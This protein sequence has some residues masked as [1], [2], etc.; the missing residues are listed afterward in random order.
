MEA[1]LLYT[2]EE[3]WWESQLINEEVTKYYDEDTFWKLSQASDQIETWGIRVV[4][5]LSKTHQENDRKVN[6][7]PMVSV[8]NL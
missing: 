6:Q 4:T 1:I 3:Y 5:P 7:P 8:S 2:G